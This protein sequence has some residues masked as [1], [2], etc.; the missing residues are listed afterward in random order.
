[1]KS[2]KHIP[3]KVVRPEC[4]SREP[5]VGVDA[6][7]MRTSAVLVATLFL[8]IV[9][10]RR[11]RYKVKERLVGQG[12]LRTPQVWKL[13]ELEPR[14]TDAQA[15]LYLIALGSLRS[16]FVLLMVPGS[17]YSCSEV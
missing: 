3:P 9:L 6:G 17:R 10:E 11:M 8:F 16:P 12:N 1:M 4:T 5:R 2:R 7:E 13:R 15:R 14:G